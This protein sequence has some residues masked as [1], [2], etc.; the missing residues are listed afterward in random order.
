MKSKESIDTNLNLRTNIMG[1]K[2]FDPDKD[3]KVLHDYHLRLWNRSFKGINV[4]HFIKKAKPPYFFN[5]HD[6]K[7]TS[8]SIITTFRNIKKSSKTQALIQKIPIKTIMELSAL[9]STVG[10]FII[11][12]GT[13]YKNYLTINQARGLHPAIK[14]RFDITLECIRLF[15]D[16]ETK[17]YPLKE[18]LINNNKF[19]DIF[20]NFKDYVDFFLLQDLVDND[21]KKVK[22]WL[23]F[24][25]F[26]SQN[27]IPKNLDEYLTF[28]ENEKSFV[29]ERNLRISK[30]NI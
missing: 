12:P 15:Y 4:F 1:L 8:D 26:Y 27:P 23:H 5:W 24:D 6:Q 9:G 10:G 29:N 30:L 11:F 18:I 7:I 2:N 20:D 19:F 13:K 16:R 25:S 14:D 22:F 3:S 28:I 17:S 21:Y